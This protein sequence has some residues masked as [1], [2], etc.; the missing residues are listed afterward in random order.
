[1]KHFDRRGQY[2]QRDPSAFF[3]TKFYLERN[4][5]VA[6]AIA[7]GS[8]ATAMQHFATFGLFEGRN[9]SDRFN[10]Q[11]YLDANPDVKAAVTAG[12]FRSAFEHYMEF[13]FA[14]GRLPVA[15]TGVP[16]FASELKVS[17][18]SLFAGK[19]TE[20]T[21]SA[22]IANPRSVDEI[23]LF[24]TDS[25]GNTNLLGKLFD[26]GDVEKGDD[27]AKDGVFTNR[28]TLAPTSP[29]QKTYFAAI[30][31]SDRTTQPTQIEILNPI[32]EEAFEQTINFNAQVGQKFQNALNFGRSEQQAIE[33]IKAFL[34]ANPSEVKPG[35]I[36]VANDGLGW[37]TKDDVLVVLDTNQLNYQGQRSISSQISANQ[38]A[39]YFR[40][41]ISQA[42]GN[43]LNSSSQI[44]V[45]SPYAFQFEPYDEG[46]NIASI[47]NDAGFDVKD[48]YND[49][50]TVEDFKNLERYGAI[51]ISTHG[52]VRNGQVIISSGEQISS[53]NSEEYLEKYGADLKAGRLVLGVSLTPSTSGN[54]LLIAPSFITK[55]SKN[56]PDSI[57]YVGACDST[58]NPTLAQ[59][60]LSEGAAAFVGY[61][62]VVLSSFAE[63]HG[64]DMFDALVEGKTVSE[65]PGINV[66]REKDRDPALFE[67]IGSD[68]AS[69]SVAELKN[70]SFEEDELLGWIT[71]G[72]TRTITALGPLSPT[73]GN[74]MAIISTGLGSVNN[75][76]SSISQKFF[77]RQNAKDII[78]NYNVISEEP[79][80][81]VD[82]EFDDQFEIIFNGTRIAKERVNTSNWERIEGI[83]FFG[84]DETVYDLGGF[85]TVT[86]DLTP[87]RGQ[88][89][90]LAMRTFDRGDS[91]YDTAA[92]VDNIEITT[93]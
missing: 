66:D 93:V 92:L 30:P 55:Y 71:K 18:D 53:S 75:S 89:V 22:K 86:Y 73:D 12:L 38:S 88:T 46:N 64:I 21:F 4:P 8:F 2:E 44:L 68:D 29:G 15:P 36:E 50:V 43:K 40:D 87:F 39:V 6:K 10:S 84:G 28:F 13:G 57:V 9:P 32:S 45:L 16:T 48:E 91:K 26:K 49:D 34:E 77:V 37:K 83:D 14:E 59:A 82:T 20:V 58:K 70:G 19:T 27:I 25:N 35:S 79:S 62:D 23:Q 24:E 81:F 54:E 5:D 60:F 67:L 56:L 90:E 74:E 51:A 41:R 63:S 52:G 3:N 31:G 61:S 72:D 47:L 7:D 76:Q 1:M 33:E 65:I 42:N 69:L 78:I 11:F 17:K 80:E 85:K